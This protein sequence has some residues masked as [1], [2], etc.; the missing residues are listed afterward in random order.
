[1]KISLDLDGLTG[2]AISQKITNFVGNPGLSIDNC[3]GQ[4]YD[5]TGNMAGKLSGVAA[6]IQGAHE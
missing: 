5:G 3:R 1:M 4:G 6:C 2:Q